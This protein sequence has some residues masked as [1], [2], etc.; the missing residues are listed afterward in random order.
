M[1]EALRLMGD[2]ISQATQLLLDYQGVIPA[3]LRSP[4]QSSSSEEPSTSSEDT[5][6]KTIYRFYG[7]NDF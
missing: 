4:S 6:Q 5:G 2:D 3:E 7:L 1:E